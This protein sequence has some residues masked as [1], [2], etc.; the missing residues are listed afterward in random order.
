MTV[1]RVPADDLLDRYGAL[2]AE[3]RAAEFPRLIVVEVEDDGEKFKA[4]RCPRCDALI[5]DG[6]LF[7]ISPAEDWADNP[8]LDDV[9]FDHR[10][11]WFSSGRP[12][13]EE[14]LYYSHG[15]E[16]GHAV[17]LPEGWTEDWA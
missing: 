3:I 11:I 9:D 8:D 10:R 16:P 2:Q 4:L 15:A 1:E 6:E 12:D 7:A 13:L 14:T 5:L 17:R